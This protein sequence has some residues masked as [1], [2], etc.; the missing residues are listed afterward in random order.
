MYILSY[1]VHAA[2]ALYISLPVVLGLSVGCEKP[3]TGTSGS[4]ERIKHKIYTC[5]IKYQYIIVTGNVHKMNRCITLPG[6]FDAGGAEDP[7]LAPSR[8][9]NIHNYSLP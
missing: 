4:I 5:S 6:V 2:V 8:S 9:M 7:P 3:M 1:I